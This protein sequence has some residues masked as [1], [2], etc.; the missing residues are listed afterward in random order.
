MMPKGLQKQAL[1]EL[2]NNH[3]GIIKMTLLEC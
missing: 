2:H 1:N 3:M